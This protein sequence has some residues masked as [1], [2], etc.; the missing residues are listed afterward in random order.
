MAWEQGDYER[1][2]TF[3]EEGLML[4][5]RFED[6]ASVAAILANLGSVAMSRMEVDRAS[7]LLEEAVAM[8]RVSGDE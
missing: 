6:T 2:I 3:G 4:A 1:A 7:A 8:Y 5:R